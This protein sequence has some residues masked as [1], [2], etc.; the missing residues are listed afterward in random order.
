MQTAKR[1][2]IN[3]KVGQHV[4]LSAKNLK[5]WPGLARKLLPRFVGPYPISH[6]IEKGGETVAVTLTLPDSWKIHPTFHVSLV[7]PYFPGDSPPEVRPSPF[8]TE[9]CVQ[10]YE[11]ARVVS[12]KFVARQLQYF[13]QWLHSDNAFSWESAVSLADFC[14][15]QIK[16]YWHTVPADKWP[17]VALPFEAP[18]ASQGD[19]VNGQDPLRRSARLQGKPGS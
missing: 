7:K 14:P 12:H 1:R 15:L 16:E 3:L 2:P 4:M 18:A 17:S 10:V 8:R 9:G 6:V 5:Y 11:I 13:V 19:R